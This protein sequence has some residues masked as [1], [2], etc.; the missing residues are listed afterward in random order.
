MN[1]L[2]NIIEQRLKMQS[3]QNSIYAITKKDIR[4]L[5]ELKKS[6]ILESFYKY[7]ESQRVNLINVIGGNCN[8]KDTKAFI[9]QLILA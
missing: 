3:V 7:T 2:Q 8:K 5:S 4:S 6:G 1:K 9:D